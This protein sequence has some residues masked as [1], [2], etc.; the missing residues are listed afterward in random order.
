MP[1]RQGWLNK[2][3]AQTPAP[4]HETSDSESSVEEEEEEPKKKAV[5]PPK[6]YYYNELQRLA[7]GVKWFGIGF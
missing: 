2:E 4:K 7:Q 6:L 5:L 1:L 3:G